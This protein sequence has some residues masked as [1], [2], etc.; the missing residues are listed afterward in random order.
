MS[1]DAGEPTGIDPGVDGGIDPGNSRRR[2]AI[3][4][5]ALVVG[6]LLVTALSAGGLVLAV[7]LADGDLFA[8]GSQTTAPP[9]PDAVDEPARGVANY[10]LPGD[11][12]QEADFT[13]F[14]PTFTTI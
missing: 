4:V 3:L 7:R 12:C 8:R 14:R 11:L 2:V 13:M 6:G 10:R 9:A 5:A 1:G